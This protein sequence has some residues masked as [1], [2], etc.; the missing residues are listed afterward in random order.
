M[1]KN[2]NIFDGKVLESLTRVCRK[3]VSGFVAHS[4]LILN[5]ECGTQAVL[6][7]NPDNNA[8]L[9]SVDEF[10]DGEKLVIK[11]SY[12][13]T[14]EIIDRIERRLFTGLKYSVFDNCEH[15]VNEVLTGIPSS[16]QLK[17]ALV[18]S[19]IGTGSLA[20]ATGKKSLGFISVSALCFGFLGLYIER[21]N[22]LTSFS[23]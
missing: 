15:L 12:I 16:A 14:Q 22:Q 13:A 5:F 11:E 19:V 6:H 18:T 1:L 21:E 7:T 4:G 2:E 3:K 9:S 20:L 8:H 10:S 23:Q 17:S